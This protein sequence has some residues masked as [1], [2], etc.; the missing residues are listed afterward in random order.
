MADKELG[1]QRLYACWRKL[2]LRLA[3]PNRWNLVRGPMGAVI[4]TLLDL[5]WEPLHPDEWRAPGQVVFRFSTS[6]RCTR[7]TC[8]EFFDY[9]LAGVV[10]GLWLEAAGRR[11]GRGLEKRPL[12]SQLL[13]TSPGQATTWKPPCSRRLQ[14]EA[15]GPGQGS[16]LQ[17]WWSHHAAS[18]VGIN[19]MMIS[20]GPGSAPRCWRLFRLQAILLGSCLDWP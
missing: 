14:L 6:V 19:V 3:A 17:C 9:L 2:T 12:L 18:G 20:I 4:A 16:M 5:G 1:E 13:R 11:N 7:S 15:C 10:D 8:G